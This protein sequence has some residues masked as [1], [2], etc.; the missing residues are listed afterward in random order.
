VGTVPGK[1]DLYVG[2]EVVKKSIPNEQAVEKL[3]ELIKE[4][5]MWVDPPEEEGGQEEKEMVVMG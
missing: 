5:D 3:V 1:V 4:Y 2:K